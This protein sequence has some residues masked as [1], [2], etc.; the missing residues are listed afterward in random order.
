MGGVKFS[1][2]IYIT[3]VITGSSEIVPQNRAKN[4]QTAEL[5]PLNKFSQP[6]L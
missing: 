4:R 1:Q 3:G 5:M 6:L 2:Y